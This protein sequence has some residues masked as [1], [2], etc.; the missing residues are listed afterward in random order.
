MAKKGSTGTPSSTEWA[1]HLRPFGKKEA[2]KCERKNAKECIEDD[3]KNLQEASMNSKFMKFLESL[4]AND[5]EMLIE[6]VKQGFRAC[7]EGE[8]EH[9][10]GTYYYDP[11]VGKYYNN[12]TDFY[13]D[14]SEVRELLDARRKK[15]SINNEVLKKAFELGLIDGN[16]YR[17][18]THRLSWDTAVSDKMVR[19]AKSAG[20]SVTDFYS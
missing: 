14:E 17:K 6:S 4:K 5:N 3:K 2:A 13:V 8:L 1:K 15:I 18:N 12:A 19:N 16:D 7:F 10:I 9:T 11:S 20:V